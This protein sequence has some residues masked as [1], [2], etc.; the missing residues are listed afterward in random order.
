MAT[1]NRFIPT[2][3]TAKNKPSWPIRTFRKLVTRIDPELYEQDQNF[4]FDIYGI[5]K[6]V[7]GQFGEFGSDANPMA[8][9]RPGGGNTIDASKAMANN[10]GFVYASVNAIGRE[11][12]NIDWRLFEVSGEDHEEQTDHELLDLLDGVN[13]DMTGP[14]LKYMLSAHLDLTG[15]AYWFLDGV[16]ND[17]DKPTAIYPLDP[18]TMKL[19]PDT[20]T[21]PFTIKG[22]QMKIESKTYNFQPY[23]ILHF[24]LPNPSNMFEGVGV[25]QAGADYID[26]DNYAQE[27]NR[28]FFQNGARPAGVLET[29]YQSETQVESLKVG[30]TSVH[31]GVD[32]MNSILV[33]PKDVKW[34]PV[35]S[36][37]K[38]MDFRN[39]SLDSRDRIL[40][41]FGVSKTILG[42]AES[43][44]N[45]ATA[46]T[47]DYVFS[48]RVIKPRMTLI[49]SFLNEKL[50]SRYGDDLYITFIDPVPEDRAA[51]TTE[52]T[53]AVGGQPIL[54]VNEARDEFMGLGPVEGGDVLMS[55]ST[56]TPSGAP[57]GDG[58]VTP[59]PTGGDKSKIFAKEKAA[60][61]ERVAFRPVR[62]KLQARARQRKGMSDELAKKV[63]AAVK[64]ALE[65]PTRKF[66]T[67][68]R[69]EAAYKAATERTIEAEKEIADTIRRINAEQYKEVTGNLPGAVEKAVDPSKLFDLEHWIGITTDAMTPIIESLYESEGKTAATELGK[70]DL[71]PLSD[72][73]AAKALHE[74]IEKMS[75]SYQ[76]TVLNQLEKAINQGLA[77]GDSLADITAAVTEVYG[78]A[79]DYGAQRIAKTEAFR[80]TNASLKETWKQSGVVKTIK[81]YTASGDPCI[82]CQSLEGKVISIDENFLNE[83]DTLTVDEKTLTADYGAIG[84]PPAHPMC[85]CITRPEDIEI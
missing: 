54:T 19:I 39:L 52:M 77:D 68:A 50:V 45:R 15:N 41:M 56:M 36:N 22:Y 25:V 20:S 82:F 62:T 23:E 29:P 17:T 73:N 80:T 40:A 66:S 8:I 6:A 21:F 70:P 34:T 28:K 13:P 46:E 57:V 75:T 64:D 51:R 3:L 69:D 49:C 60:N 2:S 42:T 65:H 26:N 43:D 71:V 53:T 4:T 84:S 35:G 59:Q 18:S 72:V 11:I 1:P 31:Q 37:P 10:R 7:G 44:T 16:K 14:E 12:M 33:L 48:K 5:R 67:K 27:F 58:D 78:A 30:F 63:A 38:D 83:G 61:G 55:P 79:D 47:A 85:F 81:W 24:R 32:N 76:T 9:Y 74:S